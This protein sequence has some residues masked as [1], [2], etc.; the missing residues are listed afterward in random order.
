MR[1]I[2]AITARRSAT[3]S[4]P[5]SE[6]RTLPVRRPTARRAPGSL[7]KSRSTRFCASAA[8]RSADQ[9]RRSRARAGARAPKEP[10]HTREGSNRLA[11]SAHNNRRRELLGR[12]LQGFFHSF[13]A[14]RRVDRGGRDPAAAGAEA[15]VTIE[16]FEGE[17][18]SRRSYRGSSKE[19]MV[20]KE[21]LEASRSVCFETLGSSYL[22]PPAIQN[23]FSPPGQEQSRRLPLDALHA[24]GRDDLDVPSGA[25]KRHRRDRRGAGARP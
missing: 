20:S 25:A 17:R 16:G 3:H 2:S 19:L 6:R 11:R 13:R 23:D 5:G 18:R 7:P 9:D 24:A 1:S 8:A 12:C 21:P 10:R 22:N 4:T 15:E 14:R